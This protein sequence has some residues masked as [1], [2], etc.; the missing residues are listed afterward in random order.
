M[1]LNYKLLVRNGHQGS[2][3]PWALSFL[4]EGVQKC[5]IDRHDTAAMQTVEILVTFFDVCLLSEVRDYLYPQTK[6][7][8]LTDF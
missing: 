2:G 6:M 1:V 4:V 5:K 8:K 7:V 3:Q